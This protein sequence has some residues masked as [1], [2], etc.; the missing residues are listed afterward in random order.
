M[1][2][3]PLLVSRLMWLVPTMFGL[4]VL[5]FILS[6]VIPID[7]AILIAGENAPA[8]QIA[9]VRQHFK[10]D[11]PLTTQF[12]TYLARLLE[13]D[14]GTSLY[15]H[16]PI[17]EE[18]WSR[19]PATIELTVA[20]LLLS[21]ILGIPTGIL[22]GLH[23]GSRLDHLVLAITVAGIGVT[24]FWLAMQLQ[25][26]FAM[27]L[28]LLPLSGRLGVPTP[29]NLT[30]LI[31]IDALLAGDW[32]AFKSAAQHLTLPALTI[33]LP[34]A[35]IV[36]RFARNSVINAVNSP[37]FTYQAAMG[38]PS[39]LIIWK[40]LFRSSIAATVTLLGLT[41]GVMLAGV[42]SVETVF[43]WPGMGSYAVRSIMYSDYQA[44]MGFT[45]FTGVTFSIL[46]VLVDI[47]QA[48]IDPRGV[49]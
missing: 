24:H 37:S 36:Q 26:A 12:V 9:Q 7:P 18:L 40:Y 30:G 48:M 17:A 16:R 47:L 45:L 2:W 21:A 29:S 28:Q 11:E 33:G 3:L 42:V 5:I 20:S 23:S 31:T 13:G 15:T 46:S 25:V 19:L 10:L 44:V 6:R 27:N 4:V 34:S 41:A 32:E 35:A 8:D 1:H 43:D 14:L 39:R 22:C 49:T 38:F